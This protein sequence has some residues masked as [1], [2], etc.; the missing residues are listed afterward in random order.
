MNQGI[1]TQLPQPPAM[2]YGLLGRPTPVPM[3]DQVYG[4]DTDA[5]D[6]IQRVE[7]ADGQQLE[8]PVRLALDAFIRACKADGIWNAIKASCI[9]AGARTLSGALIPLVGT[10]PTNFNFVAADYNRK[11]GLLGNGSTK[12]LST[13]IGFATINAL[14]FIHASCFVNAA[15][16]GFYVASDAQNRLSGTQA[17]VRNVAATLVSTTGF[18][19]M[20]YTSAGLTARNNG[21]DTTGSG[22]PTAASASP[23]TIFLQ[24][25]SYS[26]AR[27]S[28]Y[29]IGE[30][31]NLALL[32]ARVTQLMNA[33]AV[34]L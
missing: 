30:T 19:G 31:L 22:A 21:A 28:F 23:V 8:L 20:V 18:Y 34:A 6:Y 13:G 11:T 17:R 5:S 1:L 4:Y 16:A 29:S 3:P 2:P 33:L 15:A 10:A 25:T 14:S 9:L 12:Y 26:A 7:A 24:G 32:D 27:L